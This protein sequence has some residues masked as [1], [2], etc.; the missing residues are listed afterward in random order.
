MWNE[1]CEKILVQC[2]TEF[3]K[4]NIR[5][6]IFRNYIG[7]PKEN[8]SKDI[9]I[10]VNPKKI[11][12]AI[13]IVK[14][15]YKEN[16]LVYYDQSTYDRL[17]CTHGIAGDFSFGIHIDLLAGYVVKGYEIYPFEHLY[18]HTKK[19]NGLT[20]PG[21]LYNGLMLFISKLFGYKKFEFKDKYFLEVYGV[22]QNYTDQFEKEI[23]RLFGE[24]QGK[25]ILLSFR[26]KDKNKLMA[27]HKIIDGSLKRYSFKQAP[28]KTVAKKIRFVALRFS[29][30]VIHYRKNKRVLALNTNILENEKELKQLTQTLNSVY[31]DKKCTEIEIN[32][33]SLPEKI[34][35]AKVL[36]HNVH[37]D[38]ISI[39][40]VKDI[41]QVPKSVPKALYINQKE[42]LLEV[43]TEFCNEYTE[44]I[45]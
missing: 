18:S 38:K 39:L 41:R 29:R 28:I 1:T 45:N 30:I 12:T 40:L 14:Q 42:K 34:K 19:Y 26:L 24:K 21:E 2:V 36:R 43:L 16:D 31:V 44:K 9:D 15:T 20:V 13:K 8:T 32:E 33:K 25:S 37:Y 22:Y 6:F 23:I 11:K 27:C 4:H 10:V 35:L 3:D 5:Y 7:L 17:I